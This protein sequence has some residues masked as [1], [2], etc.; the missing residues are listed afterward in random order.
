MTNENPTHLYFSMGVLDAEGDWV[1]YY[2]KIEK[3]TNMVEITNPGVPAVYGSLQIFVDCVASELV[4]TSATRQVLENGE[5]AITFEIVDA[6]GA[7]WIGSQNL[8]TGM[9][10]E[11]MNGEEGRFGD[12]ISLWDIMG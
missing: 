12:R 7:T 8:D 2:G 4:F 6:S 10:L 1:V 5:N 9:F 11:F 3:A